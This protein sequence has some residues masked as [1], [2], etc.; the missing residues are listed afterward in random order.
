VSGRDSAIQL[1][2]FNERSLELLADAA[3]IAAMAGDAN[4]AKKLSDAW[5]LA[6]ISISEAATYNLDQ[7]Q[8]ALTMISRLNNVL[9]PQ[10]GRM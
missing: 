4:R 10:N 1:D 8:H 6:R 7:K 9:K 3:A 5:H 2:V